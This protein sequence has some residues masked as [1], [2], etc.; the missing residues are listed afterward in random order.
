MNLFG[1]FY[2]LC[3]CG[4]YGCTYRKK[5]MSNW[6]LIIWTLEEN[7]REATKKRERWK[8]NLMTK[9][10]LINVSACHSIWIKSARILTARHPNSTP[11]H[12]SLSEKWLEKNEFKNVYRSHFTGKMV[13][14]WKCWQKATTRKV[15]PNFLNFL[16]QEF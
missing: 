6:K 16:S 12:A 7:R 13:T 10:R 8:K 14:C 2:I 1:G 5:W 3:S 11:A 9:N 15:P 4:C